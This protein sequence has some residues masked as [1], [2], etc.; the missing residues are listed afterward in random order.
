MATIDLKD[1]NLHI[2][3]RKCS[4]IFLRFAIRCP[5]QTVYFQFN[6]LPFG[7]TAALR[8][9]TNVLVDSLQTLRI[10]GIQKIYL[11]AQNFKS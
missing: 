9:F 5:S 7:L 3:I 6:A 11:R 1:A 10:A 8:I 4:R 2:P